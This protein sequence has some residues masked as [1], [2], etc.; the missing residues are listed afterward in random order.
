MARKVSIQGK[1]LSCPACK[2]I[3]SD[4]IRPER[5]FKM[6]GVT[7]VKQYIVQAGGICPHCKIPLDHSTLKE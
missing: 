6:E 5:G 7:T 3:L 2:T 4:A 1:R